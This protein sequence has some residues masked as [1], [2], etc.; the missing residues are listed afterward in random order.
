MWRG[1]GDSWQFD[2]GQL[3]VE[4]GGEFHEEVI[5]IINHLDMD[6]RTKEI[7]S[8]FE[9]SWVETLASYD[10]AINNYQGFECFKP[11]RNFIAELKEKGN[12]KFFRIGKSMYTLVI[13]RSVNHG[14]RLDQKCIKIE[15]VGQG[16]YKV[17]F[18]NGDINHRDYL[19]SDLHD[20]KLLGLL[21]TLKSTLVD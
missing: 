9:K 2:S 1:S 17:V 5:I 18:W 20:D 13:S 12:D 4:D 11:I 10:Y 15:A 14:L 16:K 3:A 21:R 7:I 19:L 6:D 8:L